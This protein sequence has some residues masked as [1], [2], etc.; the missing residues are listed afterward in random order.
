MRIALFRTFVLF[1]V[2]TAAATCFAQGYKQPPKEIMDVLNAP[3]IPTTTISPARDKIAL[4]EPLRYPPITELAQ[5]MLRIAGLRINPNTNAQHRE[6]YSTRLTLKNISDGKDTAVILPPCE[7][8]VS[9]DLSPD[10]RPI[11]L[12]H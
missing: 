1:A 7:K 11:D 10:C 6:I 3:V 12:A 5:P 2:I 8:I 4:L 9:L